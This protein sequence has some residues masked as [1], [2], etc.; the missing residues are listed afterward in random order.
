[1]EYQSIEDISRYKTVLMKGSPG[2]G[3]TFK[4]AHFPAPVFIDF[5]HNLSGLQK[6]PPEVRK[7]IKVVDPRIKGGKKLKGRMVWDNAMNL[8]GEVFQ[9]ENVQT[10]II[11]SLTT[12]QEILM[13]KILANEDPSI[14]MKRQDWGAVQRYWK[15]FSEEIL[16][17]GELDKHVI[18]TAHERVLEEQTVSGGTV[19]KY[20]LNLSGSMRDSFDVYFSDVWRCYVDNS[21]GLRFMVATEPSNYFSAKKSIE[22]PNMFEWDKEKDNIIKQL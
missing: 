5:D 12:M 20:A 16:C 1:M 9:D 11:D 2:S 19:M 6:L 15:S 22:C 17:N 21:K 13:D 10:V 3:K 18:I 8:L 14:Q 7:G 4:A